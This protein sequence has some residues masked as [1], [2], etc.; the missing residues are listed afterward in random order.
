MH[1]QRIINKQS[2]YCP[3]DIDDYSDDD[4]MATA[5]E[6]MERQHLPDIT[7]IMSQMNQHMHY[8]I[9]IRYEFS[10]N[11]LLCVCVCVNDGLCNGQ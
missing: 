8:S 4:L 5:R 1:R 7:L 2:S 6:Y 10:R 3:Y 9:E 11:H